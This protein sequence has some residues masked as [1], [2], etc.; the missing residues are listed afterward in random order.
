MSASTMF[1]IL[2]PY[3]YV[4]NVFAIDYKK[5]YEKGFRGILFDID[6]TLV[7][8]GDDST[9]EID[10]LF[11]MVQSIGFQTLLLTDN[12][13]ERVKRFI[14]NIHTPYICEAGKPDPAPYRKALE[15][16]DLHKDQVVCIGD[17][18]FTDIL[19]ANRSGIPSILVQFIR[20]KTEKRIGKKRQIEKLI[21]RFYRRNRSAQH[22][23]GDIWKD[24]VE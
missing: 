23:L 14:K 1:Q 13:E 21:L 9:E 19:G 22:R 16:L 11:A 24:K 4:E 15:L 17:Q 10:Q 18:M 6:N 2:Y 12:N 3:E 5:L 20:L 8:H 7:H